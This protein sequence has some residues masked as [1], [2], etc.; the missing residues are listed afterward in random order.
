VRNCNRVR[1]EAQQHA[2]EFEVLLPPPTAHAQ[3]DPSHGG[4]CILRASRKELSTAVDA[5]PERLE[6]VIAQPDLGS[7][8][9]IV[10]I[11]MGVLLVA[12]AK[13]K[14]I[15]LISFLSITTVAAAFVSDFVNDYQKQRLAGDVTEPA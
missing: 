3:G 6:L 13:A 14:Y 4:S 5:Q 11:A 15:G 8:S 7:A 1:A 10:T 2:I 9:V 12:G